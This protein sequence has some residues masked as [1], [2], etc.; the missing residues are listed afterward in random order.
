MQQE[1]REQAELERHMKELMADMLKL[2]FLLIEN[3]HLNQALKQGNVLMETDFLH[4]LKVKLVFISPP[5]KY[6]QYTYCMLNMCVY[7]ACVCPHPNSK[8]EECEGLR[9]LQHGQAS[10]SS[11]LRDKQLQLGELHRAR[12]VLTSDFHCLQDTKERK[13]AHLVSLQG[14]AKQLQAVHEGRYS[15]L[16]TGEALEPALQEERLHAVATILHRVQQEFP[17]HQGALR[18]LSLALA[19]CLLTPLGQ[20][21]HWLLHD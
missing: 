10:L 14:R 5:V 13:L 7:V 11:S 4:R 15:A 17:Q 19:A 16:S 21:T 9:E 3:R 2:N 1:Q 18:R 20:E 8:A 6:V 12:T